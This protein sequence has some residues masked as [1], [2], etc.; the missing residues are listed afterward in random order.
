MNPKD[1]TPKNTEI[2]NRYFDNRKDW[3]EIY[4]KEKADKAM[5]RMFALLELIPMVLCISGMIYAS[6]L[7]DVIPFIFK[8]DASGGITALGIPNKVL[9][10]DNGVVA[11]QLALFI[12]T[13]RQVPNSTEIRTTYVRHVKMMS[14]AQLFHNSLVPMI[15]DQYASIGTGN[16]SLKITTVLPVSKDTWELDWTEYRNGT[17]AGKFRAI[18]N[19]TRSQLVLKNPEEMIWNPLGII[20]KDITINQVIGS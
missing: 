14:T 15:K 7:P 17:A 8:E 5:W 20:V 2:E 6:G 3:N 18:I 16:L 1:K 19:I 12:E 4:G 10:V 9:K 13:L 11:N